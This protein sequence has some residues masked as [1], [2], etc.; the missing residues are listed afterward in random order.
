MNLARYH[1]GHPVSLSALIEH[2]LNRKDRT[3][4]D[5]AVAVGLAQAVIAVK[6]VSSGN[7]IYRVSGLGDRV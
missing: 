7:H 5:S 4:G 6:T 1:H 3:S 2:R